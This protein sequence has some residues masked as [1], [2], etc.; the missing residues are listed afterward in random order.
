MSINNIPE[1]TRLKVLIRLLKDDEQFN[2]A[3]SKSGL[4][5]NIAQQF[6]DKNDLIKQQHLNK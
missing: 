1:N 2:I 4:S 6:L 3:C 5:I